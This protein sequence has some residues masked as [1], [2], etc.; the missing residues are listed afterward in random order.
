MR[1]DYAVPDPAAA[2]AVPSPD[3]SG[4][5]PA[6]DNRPMSR[7]LRPT[8]IR[9]AGALL[10][11][12]ASS[13]IADV[14]RWTDADGKVHYT[15]S[16]P[17]GVKCGR[18]L[19]VPTG[20]APRPDGSAASAGQP[21]QQEAE[22]QRRRLERLEA[23]RNAAE[24]RQKAEQQ[25]EACGQARGRLTWLQNGGRV[26]RIDANG[27]RHFLDDQEMAREMALQQQR[28]AQLCR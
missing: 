19:K 6:D 27:E 23:D 2:A 1:P 21:Q 16:P 17:A 4:G 20:P 15:E 12:A 22:F 25:K 5:P 28:I 8:H 10:W 13:A 18:T 11:L 14:C 9:L 24:D 3:W 7:F 26:A